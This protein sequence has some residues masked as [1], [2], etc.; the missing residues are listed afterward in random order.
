MSNFNSRS[1]RKWRLA[2]FGP[3]GDEESQMNDSSSHSPHAGGG[4]QH[5]A[6]NLHDALDTN[7]KS[8]LENEERKSS[9]E[10][11]GSPAEAD[12]AVDRDLANS[13]KASPPGDIQPLRKGD[14]VVPSGSM[15]LMSDP[16]YSLP[17][18]AIG[19]SPTPQGSKPAAEYHGDTSPIPTDGVSIFER[20]GSPKPKEVSDSKIQAN[21]GYNGVSA[22]PFLQLI[23]H[24]LW[25]STKIMSSITT[26][27]PFGI[28]TGQKAG[29]APNGKLPNLPNDVNVGEPQV[30]RIYYRKQ[31]AKNDPFSRLISLPNFF[32]AARSN[33]APKALDN[34]D[35]DLVYGDYYP[36]QDSGR[37]NKLR[38]HETKGKGG[39]E[40]NSKESV[41]EEKRRSK[42]KKK[43]SNTNWFIS[44]DVSTR[45]DRRMAQESGHA[46]H[47]RRGAG[48]QQQSIFSRVTQAFL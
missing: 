27:L 40:E 35:K 24:D 3:V 32:S 46:A 28:A 39:T 6:V 4:Q 10:A 7:K 9:D 48:Y 41:F 31:T 30:N 42:G 36:V 19:F 14:T 11:G 47:F 37:K 45:T 18:G 34:Y 13:L 38:V 1:W 5:I 44:K 15:T 21:S 12:T 16:T 17:N 23:R 25:N 29:E 43:E 8:Q 20:I 33:D 22:A 26:L 2:R